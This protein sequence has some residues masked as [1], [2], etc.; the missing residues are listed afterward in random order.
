MEH[1]GRTCWAAPLGGCSPK[2]TGEHII[3]ECLFDEKEIMVQGLP[4]CLDQPKSI[5]KAN[6]TRNILCKAHNSALSELD[7]AALDAFNVFRESTKLSSAR[8]GIRAR[9]L[10]LRKFVINGPLLERWF[11]K[12]FIN[13]ALGQPFAIGPGQ[14]DR[15]VPSTELVE[16]AFGQRSF[17]KPSGLY[18]SGYAGEKE[19]SEDRVKIVTKSEGANLVAAA[20]SFRGCRFFLNLLPEKFDYDGIST[21]LYRDSKLRCFVH[22]YRGRSLLSHQIAIQW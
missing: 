7:S 21:L 19:V 8:L 6:L 5:G 16:I 14:H 15:G 1:V 4:W 11:L 13:V 2:I 20:F 10:S 12:T 9:S 18:L 17:E 3:S 22:N